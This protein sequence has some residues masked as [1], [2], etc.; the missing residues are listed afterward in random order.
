MQRLSAQDAIFLYIEDAKNPMHVGSVAMFEGPAPRYGDLIRMV[1]RKL[2]LVPRY[3]QRVR[4][5]PLQLGRPVWAD[6]PHFQLLYHVRHTAVPPPGGDDELR[7]LAGRLLAQ[8]L[9]RHKPLW[10]IWMVEGLE[11][12]RWAVV[13]KTH[14]SMVDGVAGTDLLSVI[15]DRSRHP[16]PLRDVP[17]APEREPSGLRLVAEACVDALMEPLRQAA[18]LP[19]LVQA[20]LRDPRRSVDFVTGL[21]GEWLLPRLAP[22]HLNGPV[23]PHRRWAWIRGSLADVKEVRRA[24]GG[25]VNDVVL[26]AVTRGY[27]ELLLNRGEPVDGRTVR[28]LVPVSVRTEAERGLLNNRVSGVFP[29]LPVGEADPVRRLAEISRQMK[30]LKESGQADVGDALVHLA[31]LLPAMS[32]A[33]GGRVGVN[34]PQRMVQ[35]VTTN[36]PGPQRPLYV[37]GRR[38]L[39]YYPYVPIGGWLRLNVAIISYLGELN[40]GATGDYDSIPDLDVFCRGVERGMAELLTAAHRRTRPARRVSGPARR[41]APRAVAGADGNHA[42]ADERVR[43]ATPGGRDGIQPLRHPAAVRRAAS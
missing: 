36:V 41:A 31:D 43:A 24:L 9:D 25:T 19:G 37:G 8:P 32:L 14:H 15:F 18:S 30:A 17:W 22:H 10:E 2:H 29:D 12:G 33:I 40:I 11:G 34:T 1:A 23:G 13:S 3:R 42:A 38:L 28:T 4:F 35:T 26:A 20:P 21:A 6:D 27:R 7:N 5:V 16:R 39:E